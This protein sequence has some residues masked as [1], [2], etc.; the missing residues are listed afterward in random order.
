MPAQRKRRPAGQEKGCAGVSG[1]RWREEGDLRRAR[2]VIWLLRL[3]C[4]LV[5]GLKLRKMFVHVGSAMR[6]VA[7]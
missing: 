5:D 7:G 6:I 3:F 1:V 4:M 2:S